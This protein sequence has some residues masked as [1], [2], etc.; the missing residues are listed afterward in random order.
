VPDPALNLERDI[1]QFTILET[2]FKST[3]KYRKYKNT[4]IAG[5]ENRGTSI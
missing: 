3:K 5:D 1:P 4:V 2:A